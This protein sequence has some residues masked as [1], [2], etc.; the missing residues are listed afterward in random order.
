LAALLGQESLLE[1]EYLDLRPSRR[2]E[3]SPVRLKLTTAK[4]YKTR[5][6]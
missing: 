6:R 3:G 4:Q 5:S 1:V 2:R